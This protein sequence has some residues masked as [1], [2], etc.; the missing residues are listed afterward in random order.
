MSAL[1]SDRGSADGSHHFHINVAEALEEDSLAYHASCTKDEHF[2]CFTSHCGG[3]LAR[4]PFDAS[5]QAD[6]A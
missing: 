6:G 3:L 5:I 4:L 1:I 2:H